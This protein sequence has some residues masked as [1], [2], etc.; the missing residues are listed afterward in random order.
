[1]LSSGMAG[2][3]T[4]LLLTITFVCR[5]GK[6]GPSNPGEKVNSL[7]SKQ[8]NKGTS[9]VQNKQGCDRELG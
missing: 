3:A 1:M 9:Y 5:R 8:R 6:Y 2:R 4:D 7:K